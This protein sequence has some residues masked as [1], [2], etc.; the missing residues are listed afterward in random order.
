MSGEMHPIIKLLNKAKKLED[1]KNERIKKIKI[2]TK[3]KNKAD[4]KEEKVKDRPWTRCANCNELN[5]FEH[6]DQIKC[7]LC[8]YRVVYKEP[9]RMSREYLCR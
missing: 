6:L 8:D 5:Y 7:S 1:E 3:N 2:N 9:T 4:A